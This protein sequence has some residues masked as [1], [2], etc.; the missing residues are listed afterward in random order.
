MFEA[1]AGG[2]FAKSCRKAATHIP[3]AILIRNGKLPDPESARSDYPK[4]FMDPI[5]PRGHPMQT[6][7]I[8]L[9]SLRRG[10]LPGVVFAL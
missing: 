9:L 5:L 1:S 10:P 8:A 7:K 2:V 4:C 6:L 3:T